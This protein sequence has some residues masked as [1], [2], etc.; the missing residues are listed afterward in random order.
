ML[1][2]KTQV[3]FVF[4]R[5][6]DHFPAGYPDIRGPFESF[7][8]WRQCATVMQREAAVVTPSCSGVDNVVVV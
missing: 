8:H 3:C 2:L 4:I 1:V 5:S 6:W 7:V